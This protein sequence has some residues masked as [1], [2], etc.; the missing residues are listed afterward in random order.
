LGSARG[1]FAEEPPKS[2]FQLITINAFAS[3]SYTWN[4]ND[5]LS[6]T[7]QL[8]AFDVDHNSIRI[9]AAELVVQK[10]VA[11]PGE[12]GV[13]FDVTFGS[14]AHIAAARGLFRDP[15]TGIA[16]DIDLQQAFASY[17]IPVG[18]GLRFDL[19]KF[20]TP[21]GYELIE[22]YDGYNDVYS[23][24]WLFAYGPYTHTGFKLT[25]PFSDKI[26]A[27]VML[28]NG[29]DNV[30]D[31]NAAKSFGVT[32]AIT[33]SPKLSVYLNYLGGPERDNDN[34]SWRSLADL[35]AVYKPFSRF[36]IALNIDYGREQN[37]IPPPPPTLPMTPDPMPPA[38]AAIVQTPDAQW[39]MIDLYLRLQLTRRFALSA[40]GEIF[41][42]VD[43]NRTGTAQRLISGTI[44]PELR[45]TDAFLMRAEFRIDGSDQRVFEDNGG[46]K[47]NHYQPTLAINGLY[48]F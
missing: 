28:A 12:F 25:Y 9:D 35:V 45:L 30:V 44:T 27:T 41:W 43:G 24:S 2:W 40:R 42:D 10:A 33:P 47:T 22:G 16:G 38:A 37:G 39:A 46:N 36:S 8:R 6:K 1:G 17:I 11:N 18:H 21:V 3:T 4:F 5:P 14:V 34:T 7:N 13:R 32:L 19:G 15:A 23:R 26:A 31:N 48:V 29:W 20:V